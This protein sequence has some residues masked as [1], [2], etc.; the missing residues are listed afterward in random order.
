MQGLKQIPRLGIFGGT[1]NPVHL[2]HLIM[3]QD[4]LEHFELSKV[5]FVPCWK[6]PHVKQS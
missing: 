3:A 2:G 4:A 1:F 6:A 5:L